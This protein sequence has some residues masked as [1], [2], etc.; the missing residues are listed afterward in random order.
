M[1][2]TP[3]SLDES[4]VVD[5]GTLSVLVPVYNEERSI[6]EVLRRVLALGPIVREVIVVD[7][8]S[9]DAT[10]LVVRRLSETESRVRFHRIERNSGKTAAINVALGL[11]RGDIVIVQD[12]D[13]EYDPAEI[14]DVVAPI[15]VGHADVVYG[16]RFLVSRAAPVS[17]FAHHV[18]NTVLTFLSNCFTNRRLTDVETCY[19]AFRTGVIK[20]LRLTSRGFG[21]E[22]EI[23]AL[24]L[25]T[26][27]RVYEVPISYYPRTYD[28]GKKIGLWDGLMAAVYLVSYNFIAP[29]L[30]NGRRYVA[31]VNG[32]LCNGATVTLPPYSPARASFSQ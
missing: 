29:Y 31:D 21:M 3:I 12:A 27:A 20:P 32:F 8:G 24:V 17:Y 22:I 14:P 25:K 15:I 1:E 6:A 7:D 9:Q 26:R 4:P 5:S 11:V 16:S 2:P 28:E 18:A 10:P 13:L 23:T 30:A 19:K